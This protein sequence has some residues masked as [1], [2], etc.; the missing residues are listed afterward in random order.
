MGREKTNKYR[1]KSGYLALAA[2]LALTGVSISPVMAAQTTFQGV[3][4]SSGTQSNA[5]G[6]GAT[7]TDAAT[8]GTN[9]KA[10][11][12]NSIAIGKDANASGLN[13]V[14]IQNA[15]ASGANTI[16]IGN[17]AKGT[18][19]DSVVM[20]SGATSNVIC[21]V[22]IGPGA[23]ASGDGNGGA[24]VIGSDASVT[25]AATVAI[26]A[27]SVTQTILATRS[28]RCLSA[29]NEPRCSSRAQWRH[30]TAPA[31]CGTRSHSIRRS[32]RPAASVPT[33]RSAN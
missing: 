32:A 23:T 27:A 10:S 29:S 28:H 31:G 8:L 4:A 2:V 33:R 1:H 13:S 15:I 30:R 6:A 9:A 12:D 7:G 16:A 24:V 3:N 21:S 14:A 26:G 18:N 25:S 17:G 22:V 5:N 19:D 11:G 20:G